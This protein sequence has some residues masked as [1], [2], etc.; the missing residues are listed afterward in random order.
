[1][2]TTTMPDSPKVVDRADLPAKLAAIR[3]GR[4]VVFTNGCFDILHPGH[5]DLLARARAQGDLL[6]VGVNSD[7]SVT[8]LKGHTRPLNTLVARMYV[9]A[10]LECVDFVTSF[11]EDTPFELISELVPEV[12]V[13]GGDWTVDNI[14]GRDVVED[15]GGTVLSL[16]LLS[17]Y[18]TTGLIKKILDIC[19][20]EL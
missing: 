3:A 18:A 16:P 11:H 12:L 17:G 19:K 6:V 15:A 14:V 5:A 9:L 10:A 7:E 2:N 4:K 13:K 8:R 20:D 1:M